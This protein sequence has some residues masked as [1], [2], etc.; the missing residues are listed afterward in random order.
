MKDIRLSLGHIWKK[1][2][3]E[4]WWNNEPTISLNGSQDFSTC[5]DIINEGHY[6]HL[7]RKLGRH[8]IQWVG[9][10]RP[11]CYRDIW[12]LHK[13]NYN[14]QL[15]LY[16]NCYNCNYPMQRGQVVIPKEFQLGL[17]CNF[18]DSW[19]ARQLAV[20]PRWAV[21]SHNTQPGEKLEKC[22]A[23]GNAPTSAQLLRMRRKTHTTVWKTTCNWN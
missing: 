5:G 15:Q 16:S 14:L 23:C 3:K 20:K 6:T 18:K 4:G 7:R 8:Y 22:K 9:Q 1:K 10:W 19:V 12:Q 2:G 13:H 17:G 11:N 21:H